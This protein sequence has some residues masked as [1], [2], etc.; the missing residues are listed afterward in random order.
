M[1]IRFPARVGTGHPHRDG[2][3]KLVDLSDPRRCTPPYNPN[4]NIKQGLGRA[5]YA[6]P[7]P[8]RSQRNRVGFDS[9]DFL[10]GLAA[11]PW[12]LLRSMLPPSSP[13]APAAPLRVPRRSGSRHGAQTSSACGRAR[14]RVF[15][16]VC[17][18][19]LLPWRPRQPPQI[20]ALP[21][22]SLCAMA[23]SGGPRLP[24]GSR[25]HLGLGD[26]QRKEGMPRAR[27]S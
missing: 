18:C 17:S 21:P 5:I 22:F 7:F 4:F 13:Q 10:A 12:G 23:E 19:L 11:H 15:A 20:S 24:E 6:F 2:H 1:L 25:W 3:G 16:S 26:P 14:L 8:N 9:L 27:H